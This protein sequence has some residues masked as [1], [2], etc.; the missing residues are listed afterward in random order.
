M[1]RLWILILSIVALPAA[2]LALEISE[3]TESCLGCHESVTPG[4]VADWKNS[5]HF[6]VSP[7]EGLAKKPLER[8][9]SAVEVGG[10]LAAYAVGCAECHTMNAEAHPGSFE[11]NGYTVHTVVSPADC[12]TCHPVEVDEYKENLMSQAY[13]NLM[14]NPFYLKMVDSVNG[15]HEY[16]EGVVKYHASDEANN[17]DSCLSCH[18]TRVRITGS[19]TRETVMGEMEFPTLSN[20][21]NIGVGRLNPDGS[22]GS[23]SPCHARHQFSIEVAR[24]PYTCAQCHKG[25][26]VPAY[27]VYAV[28]V[29]GNI[30]KSIDKNWHYDAVPWTVG[31][32]FTAPTCATCHISL[33][34]DEEGEVL[35]ERSHRM[36]DRLPWRIFGLPYAHPHPISADTATIINRAG[37][38]LPTELSGE[39]VDEFLIDA[40]EMATRQERMTRVCLGCHGRQWVSGHFERLNTSIASTN[41]LTL[42]ATRMMTEAWQAGLASDE[43]PF[44][45]AIEFKWVEQWLFFGNSTRFASAMGGTDY[46]VFDN[47]RWWLQKNLQEMKDHVGV[48]RILKEQEGR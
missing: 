44:D 8:R 40:E 7:A 3:D 27:K 12:A 48:L 29:H 46:G 5:M 11:H 25:P 16:R 23:C 31:T 33:V 17:A 6:R 39:P 15:L 38:H 32:D 24:K 13:G 14:G 30:Q 42:Q 9:I 1:E 47:G 19:E 45:E 36:N 21:P 10:E 35:A 28:S 43:N 22:I 2:S 34:V 41:H 4:I 18:G 26:D 37:L 20:W